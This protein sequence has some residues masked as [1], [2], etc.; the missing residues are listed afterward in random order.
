MKSYISIILLIMSIISSCYRG[1][2]SDTGSVKEVMDDMVT[3]L[4]QTLSPEQLDTIGHAWII[5]NLSTR[6]KQVLATKYWYFDVNKP[7]TVSLMRDM[8]QV[9]T[10]F[11]LETSGFIKTDYGGKKHALDL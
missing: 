1:D 10:P 8:D 11:W 2:S 7:V 6:E 4:Y 3:R 5:D 9:N